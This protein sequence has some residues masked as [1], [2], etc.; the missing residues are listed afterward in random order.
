V[1]HEIKGST[2]NNFSGRPASSAGLRGTTW[3]THFGIW[4]LLGLSFAGQNYFS[5]I[6]FGN[7]VPLSRALS[8]ALCDWY[9]LGVLFYPTQ[10]MCRRFPLERPL[11]ARHVLVHILFGGLFSMAHIALYV[12]GRGALN[13]EAFA[14]QE[15]FTFWFIRRFH[16]NLFYYWTFVIVSHA[17]DYYRRLRERERK[18]SE[19]EARLAQAQLHAL[20]MQLQPH[21]LF[22]TLHTISE[23]IHEEPETADRMIMRLSELLR[24]TLDNTT[25]QEVPLQHEIDFLNRYLEIERARLGDRLTVGLE[26]DP[27][28]LAA[29]VPNLIL[30]P[31]VENA[32]RHGIAPY[33]SPGKV[34]IRS[35]QVNGALRL[36]VRDTGSGTAEPRRAQNQTG[37]GLANTRARLLQLYGQSQNFEAFRDALG[38]FVVTITIP[39]QADAAAGA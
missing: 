34:T 22:N 1:A 25:T 6:A 2:A 14:F 20:K 16:G 26:I 17:L 32:I 24:L 4:T 5:A 9:V 36:Q 38:G 8:A 29:K 39:C 35:E 31:L 10:R 7:R 18:A 11:L 13:P 27:A 30:Q 23:M 28:T 37:V 21:F 33:S 3:L 15:S 12:L 19:L